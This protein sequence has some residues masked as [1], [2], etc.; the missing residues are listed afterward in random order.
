[1]RSNEINPL[2]FLPPHRGRTNKVLSIHYVIR[3]GVF[4][5][6]LIQVGSV[7]GGPCLCHLRQTEATAAAENA[8]PRHRLEGIHT[9]GLLAG[10]GGGM[11][12]FW[13]A[14]NAQD[15]SN[16]TLSTNARDLTLHRPMVGGWLSH[17]FDGAV[18]TYRIEA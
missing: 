3:N 1:M 2:P 10:V 15:F 18:R 17:F 7:S 14:D 13:K 6:I 4:Q 12:W 8:V 11:L 5:T 16:L 9:E